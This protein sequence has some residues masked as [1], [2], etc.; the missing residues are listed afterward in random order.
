MQI[1]AY[2][3]DKKAKDYTIPVVILAFLTD[4]GQCGADPTAVYYDAKTLEISYKSVNNFKF[5]SI[6]N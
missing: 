1:K 3:F 4:S 6:Q 2:M 5:I